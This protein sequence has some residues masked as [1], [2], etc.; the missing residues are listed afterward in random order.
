MMKLTAPITGDISAASGEL[1]IRIDELNAAADMLP[2]AYVA[3]RLLTITE[4]FLE[5]VFPGNMKQQAPTAAIRMSTLR[6]NRPRLVL[7]D[8]PQQDQVYEQ[9]S[10]VDGLDV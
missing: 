6:L 4:H 1:A 3:Q 2:E 7:E 9:K 10:E 8:S 5:A